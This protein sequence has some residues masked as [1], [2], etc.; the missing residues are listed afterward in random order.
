MEWTQIVPFVPLNNFLNF[1]TKI[2]FLK[3]YF[4]FDKS[5]G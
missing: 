4:Y 5:I 3:L 1:K 2:D